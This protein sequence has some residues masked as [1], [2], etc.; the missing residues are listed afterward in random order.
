M[1]SVELKFCVFLILHFLPNLVSVLRPEH[2]R[3]TSCHPK[4]TSPTFRECFAPCILLRYDAV[5]V[6]QIMNNI[7]D[8]SSRSPNRGKCSQA[9]D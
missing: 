1:R 2:C 8:D 6:S 5:N 7:V 9:D 3:E 4:G